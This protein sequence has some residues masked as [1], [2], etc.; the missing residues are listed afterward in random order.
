MEAIEKITQTFHPISLKEMDRVKLLN[1]TDTKFVMTKAQ[2][3]TLL[4]ELQATYQVLEI[5]KKRSARYKTLYFDT[6]QYNFYLNHHNGVPNRYKVRIRKYIDS[7]LC[8]FE[9]KHKNKGRT[10]KRRIRIED[11]QEILTT[12]TSNFLDNILPIKTEIKPSIWNAF[13]R[14]TLVNN[15]RMERLTFDIGLNFEWDNEHFGY[16]SI[17]IAEVKQENLDRMAPA[18]QIF[19]KYG[20]RQK[21]ISKYCIGMGILYKELKNNRFKE[22]YLLLNKLQ[23]YVGTD[24]TTN[25]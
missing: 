5:N 2:F 6:P 13:E 14:I 12:E 24:N 18:I 23:N 17:I 22:K 15:E 4:P 25:N 21:R 16:S 9:I 11:F 20:I 3:T 1:R 7:D 19:K 10:D 8:F